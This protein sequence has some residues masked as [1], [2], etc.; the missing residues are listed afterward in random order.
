M[1]MSDLERFT[2]LFQSMTDYY[3]V[4][5]LTDAVV[6]ML[7][8]D[9]SPYEFELIQVASRAHRR[10]P[11]EGRFFPKAA[12]IIKQIH[13]QLIQCKQSNGSHIRLSDLNERTHFSTIYS[14]T[15]FNETLLEDKGDGLDTDYAFAPSSTPSPLLN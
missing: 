2:N 15:D 13:V 3:R 8:D 14:R 1:N 12:H 10:D 6:A 9:L 11:D 4:P 7:F 5:E